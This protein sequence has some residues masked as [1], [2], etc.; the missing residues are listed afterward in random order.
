[1]DASVVDPEHFV[2]VGSVFVNETG[3]DLS[4]IKVC[5]VYSI[6]SLKV[7]FKF[8]N[9]HL[10]SSKNFKC[11]A[12]AA[13]LFHLEFVF[14]FLLVLFSKSDFDQHQEYLKEKIV[15]KI[16]SDICTTLRP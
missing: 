7:A 9:K 2:K 15:K 10:F 13:L 8:F 11:N 6:L 16:I 1:V 12:A 3:S 14:L 5:E 4:V